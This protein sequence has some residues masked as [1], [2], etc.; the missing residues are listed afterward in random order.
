VGPVLVR[1]LALAFAHHSD[2]FSRRRRGDLGPRVERRSRQCCNWAGAQVSEKLVDHLRGRF[3][4][5]CSE[6]NPLREP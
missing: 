4:R 1:D 2:I 3:S 5:G 6:I